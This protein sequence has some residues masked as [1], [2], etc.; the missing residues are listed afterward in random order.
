MRLTRDHSLRK[1][2]QMGARNN[3]GKFEIPR[4]S[5][6]ARR[7]LQDVLF[8]FFENFSNLPKLFRAPKSILI[9]IKEIIFLQA[10]GNMKNGSKINIYQF[11]KNLFSIFELEFTV[12]MLFSLL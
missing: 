1:K 9:V 4:F 11:L 6:T 2:G 10:F 12:K 5:E 8:T 3:F 7:A